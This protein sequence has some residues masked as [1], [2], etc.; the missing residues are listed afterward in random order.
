V[1][2]KKKP[3]SREKIL[4]HAVRLADRDGVAKLSMRSV[5]ETLNVEAMSL[6]NHI[7]NK[8]DLLNGMVDV[9]VSEFEHPA[10]TVPWQLAMRKCAIHTHEVLLTH[11]WAAALLI[12]FSYPMA[13]HAWNAVCNHLYGYTLTQV[14]SPI[15]SEDYSRTAEH[16]LPMVPEADYPYVNRLIRLIVSGEHSGV[17]DFAFGLDLILDG[18]A[19]KLP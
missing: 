6:Y 5:A 19:A 16:Y 18:L 13:D 7:K 8:D 11:P 14:N 17:N 15:A 1:R 2:T 10:A 3:L 12:S 9:V 4:L